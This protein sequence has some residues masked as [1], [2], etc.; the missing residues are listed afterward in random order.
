[1]TKAFDSA[2]F[3]PVN[4]LSG[5]VVEVSSP[6]PPLLTQWASYISGP[7]GTVVETDLPAATAPGQTLLSGPAPD[8]LWTPATTTA[9]LPVPTGANQ[10][11]VSGQNAPYSMQLAAATPQ[12]T[13]PGQIV[14]S[15]GSAGG[16]WPYTLQTMAQVVAQGGAVTN[17]AGGSLSAGANIVYAPSATLTTRLDG[18]NPA[19]SAIDNFSIDMGTF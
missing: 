10:T 14:V 11:Y 19:T 7:P 5:E 15:G 1:M 16:P 3:I 8:F 6:G 2:L 18:G 4:P 13:G 9:S 17:V 12:P